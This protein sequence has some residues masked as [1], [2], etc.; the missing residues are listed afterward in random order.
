MPNQFALYQIENPYALSIVSE[1][2]GSIN[3][4]ASSQNDLASLERPVFSEATI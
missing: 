4:T 3:Q 1:L 2:A